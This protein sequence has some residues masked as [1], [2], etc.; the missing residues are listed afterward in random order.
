MP[1][2]FNTLLDPAIELQTQCCNHIK[3]RLV[4]PDDASFIL[5]IR[6][7]EELNRHISSVENDLE[8]QME[9]IV[10]YK[11]RELHGSEFYFIITLDEGLPLGTV[12]LYDFQQDSFCWGS[13]VILKNAPVYAGIESALSIYELAFYKLGFKQ[14]HFDVRK[15]NSK[16]IKFHENF[17]AKKVSED[18][19]IFNFIYRKESYEKIKHKYKKYLKS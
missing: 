3:L 2:S 4:S 13:W 8:K 17:G 9:W 6:L 7:D 18:L 5:K 12:R 10:N 15:E 1:N 19:E 14:S 16:V 11:E